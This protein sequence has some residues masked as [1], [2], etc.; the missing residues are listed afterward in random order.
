MRSENLFERNQEELTQSWGEEC[1]AG[2]E[3]QSFLVCKGESQIS[4]YEE[5]A[6]RQKTTTI[7]LVTLTKKFHFVA[8][9]ISC[10]N[11][12]ND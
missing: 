9:V 12:C 1:G 3:R 8:Y 2:R 5:K 10:R 11:A 7:H 6:I 4:K